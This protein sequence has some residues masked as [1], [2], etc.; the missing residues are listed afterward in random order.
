MI[1][2]GKLLLRSLFYYWKSHLLVSLG[3]AISTMV[4]TGA[5]II[6]DSVKTSLLTT[7]QLR[8]GR[9]DFVFQGIDRFFRSELAHEVQNDLKTD[10]APVLHV[11]GVASSQGGV[12][13]LPDINVWGIDEQFSKMTGHDTW[14]SIPGRNE[15]FISTNLA[16][17]LQLK[18]GDPVLLRL[19]K[20]SP[21]P[22]NAPFVSETDNRISI[23]LTVKQILSPEQLGQFNLRASQTAPFNAFVSQSALN[24]L[25]GTGNLANLLLFAS[26]KK[27]DIPSIMR[28]VRE[29]WTMQDAGLSIKAV[30]NGKQWELKSERVFIEPVVVEAVKKLEPE[31]D[32]LLT[33]FANAFNK[34]TLSTPY[35]F[36]SA[37]S[38]INNHADNPGNEL[39]INEW[40]AEDLQARPG[41]SIRMDYFVMAPLRRLEEK[42]IWLRVKDVVP[43]TN[44]YDESL[45]PSIPGLTDAG[46]CRDWETG[47]PIDLDK[48]R[49]KDESYW[50]EWKGTPKAFIN[51][52][53]G[54]KLW[55][56]R[57]GVS[58]AIRLSAE[59]YTR[60]SIEKYLGS[61]LNPS[62]FGFGVDAVE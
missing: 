6:G 55:E 39:L 51:Y 54:K 44:P 5:L 12:M 1:S 58:T 42:S 22:K 19:E 37:G 60:E 23:R 47:I 28:S 61:A 35:S 50:N 46:N 49:E 31:P 4:L 43:M 41:D 45:M 32:L 9:T 34:D 24:E 18:T 36:I 53:L 26:S 10:V 16:S 17:R 13:K 7:A 48:I 20:A 62:E 56:N 11:T 25:M 27:V 14:Q 57:F 33:Y 2:L 15:V 8:L 52:Q 59:K 38:F 30:N 40:L 29:H 21:L 3:A